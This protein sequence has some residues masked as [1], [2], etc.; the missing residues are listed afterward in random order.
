[1][2]KRNLCHPVST[3]RNKVRNIFLVAAL[4]TL[5]LNPASAQDNVFSLLKSDIRLADEYFAKRNHRK[6]L[7]IYWNIYKR[8]AAAVDVKI[9]I[10]RCYYGLREYSQA[11]AVYETL[12]K[13]SSVLSSSD[14]YC[15]AEAQVSAANHRKAIEAYRAYLKRTPGDAI[16]TQKLWRLSNIEY[17]YEDSIHYIVH[18]LAL[19]TDASELS[20]VPY[21]NSVVFNSNLK[22][23]S[24]IEKV[25]ASDLPLYKSYFA[26]RVADSLSE[27]LRFSKPRPFAREL[28]SGSHA[29]PMTFYSNGTKM[30][31]ASSSSDPD[32]H[33]L[34]NL[35][36]FFAENKNGIWVTSMPFPYNN[37]NYSL[38]D[39][40]INEAGT[41]LYYASDK[42]AGVGGKDIY[43]SEFVNGKW[44]TP[45][46]LGS[47][48]NTPFD[49]CTPYIQHERTLYFS[50]NGHAG[51][52]GLD[53]FKTQL[54]GTS[55]DEVVNIG[56]PVNSSADEFGFTV[57]S[58][59][60]KGYFTSNR[61]NGGMDDDLFQVDIDLQTYPVQIRGLVRMKDHS[62]SDSTELK[63]F[64]LAKLSLIDNAQGV[65]VHESMSDEKGFFSIII[66][67]HSQYKIRIVGPEKDE[68]I[69]GL[70]IPKQR[71]EYGNHEIV[72]VKDLFGTP[73]N[74]EK[75]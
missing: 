38:T 74:Q 21:N 6:A 45:E 71:K 53:I 41:I 7:D 23:I 4:L 58:L 56:Y 17:L 69:V 72:I 24:L 49:E 48:I 55:W 11:A 42:P 67:Y 25:D 18:P 44:Q 34:R 27:G 26:E 60:T 62:W 47:S 22:E 51:L 2:C 64:P 75:K 13:A 40:S 3:M 46:N 54:H 28:S 66:P 73:G 37:K 9:K 1:M 57:D 15:Y 14:L 33:G 43:R 63:P 50:S 70:E 68:H 61:K 8:N 20:V 30:V 10:A 39:P 65:S 59:T 12:L 31:F 19:N 52:G 16:V 29:G 35:Q 36:L 32:T 5:N